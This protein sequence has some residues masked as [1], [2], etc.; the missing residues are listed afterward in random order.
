M[1]TKDLIKGEKYI[2]KANGFTPLCKTP[3][4]VI[5][6]DI[7]ET[8][9]EYTDKDNSIFLQTKQ[10]LDRYYTILEKLK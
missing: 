1:T 10:Y 2:I 4:K 5:I 9:I 7:T 8:C 6:L 3:K